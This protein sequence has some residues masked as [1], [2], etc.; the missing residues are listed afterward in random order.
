MNQS[1]SKMGMICENYLVWLSHCIAVNWTHAVMQF[2]SNCQ[3]SHQIR[4]VYCLSS[5]PPTLHYCGIIKKY[6]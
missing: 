6:I 3:K 4:Q 1:E 2:V 5:K